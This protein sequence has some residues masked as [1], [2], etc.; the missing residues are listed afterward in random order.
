M[1]RVKSDWRSR[2]RPSTV[3][4]LLT[5]QLSDTTMR[6]FVPDRAI[7]LWWQL[8]GRHARRPDTQPHGPHGRRQRSVEHDDS[9]T[10][11]E[12]D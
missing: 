11:T 2:L 10:E 6:S 12:S 3:N 7:G 1:R 8:S 5:V 4:D 9:V